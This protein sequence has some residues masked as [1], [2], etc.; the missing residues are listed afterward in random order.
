MDARF[1]SGVFA[2]RRSGSIYLRGWL[3]L[4]AELPRKYTMGMLAACAG[5]L[6]RFG[7][8]SN[9]QWMPWED[10]CWRRT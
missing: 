5:G 9:R 1:E 8:L 7:R 4:H 3:R 10:C 2:I 6:L